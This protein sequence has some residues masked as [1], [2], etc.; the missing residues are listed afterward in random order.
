MQDID[1]LILGAG[2]TGLT[3][4]LELSVQNIPFYILS[5]KV[6]RSQKSRAL[7]MHS[8]TLEVLGR[9]GRDITKELTE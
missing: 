9:H 1:V 6:A 4:A 3:L 5:K 7:V 8:C 2:P